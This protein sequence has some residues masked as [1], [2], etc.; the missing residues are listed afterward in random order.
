MKDRL[1]S[2]KNIKNKDCCIDEMEDLLDQIADFKEF[3]NK[4]HKASDPRYIQEYKLFKQYV[5]WV[6]EDLVSTS[7]ICNSKLHS[8]H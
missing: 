4:P 1:S 3:I 6:S 5:K 7:Y 2:V 8:K